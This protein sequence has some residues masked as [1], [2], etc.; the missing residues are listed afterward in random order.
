MRSAVTDY[1]LSLSEKDLCWVAFDFLEEPVIDY[2]VALQWVD[3]LSDHEVK[4]IWS[5][6][7]GGA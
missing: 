3:G 1:L 5:D 2:D 6:M 4:T 7:E